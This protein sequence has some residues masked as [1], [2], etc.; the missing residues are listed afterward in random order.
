MCAPFFLHHF[1]KDRTDVPDTALRPLIEANI[2]KTQ[3]REWYWAVMDYGSWLKQTTGNANVRSRHYSKQSR[4]EGSRRQVRGA[5]LRSLV[6]RPHSIEE[7]QRLI[8]DQRL[9]SVLDDLARE[10]MV[11]QRQST[12]YL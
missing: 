9:Q 3:P 10:G 6:G 8:P 4:F 12:F 11:Q 2:S 5:V 1:F 7:L